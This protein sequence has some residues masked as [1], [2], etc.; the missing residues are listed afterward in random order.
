MPVIEPP[1]NFKYCKK[2]NWSE[3][4]KDP[5]KSNCLVKSKGT[6]IKR[7]SCKHRGHRTSNCTGLYYDV[8]LCNDSSLCTDVRTTIA[9]FTMKKSIEYMKF[10]KKY[11]L[12]DVMTFELLIAP[13]HQ[14]L[15]DVEK[16]WIACTIFYRQKIKPRWYVTSREFINYGVDT[17]PMELGV[18][19]M[20]YRIITVAS[21]IVCQKIIHS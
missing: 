19:T 12:R 1:Y 17:F 14:M 11:K 6:L 4:K 15:H 21:T 20:M 13:G 5:C 2:D 8:N 18:T 7:R 3:W 9:E 10:A 16:P